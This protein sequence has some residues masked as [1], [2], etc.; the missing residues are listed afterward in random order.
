MYLG[1]W[2]DFFSRDKKK[3]RNVRGLGGTSL[4][5]PIGVSCYKD[6][7]AE[8]DL[9]PSELSPEVQVAGASLAVVHE[10]LQLEG[11][12]QEE[13][14]QALVELPLLEDGPPA[15]LQ[16]VDVEQTGQD[17]SALPGLQIIICRRLT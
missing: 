8:L 16:V 3:K 2:L 4:S 10:D 7:P 5:T 9:S 15:L 1:E 17:V 14:P 11:S 13:Y 12:D 6:Q